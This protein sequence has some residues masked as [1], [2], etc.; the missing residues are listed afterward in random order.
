VI[1]ADDDPQ[2]VGQRAFGDLI[3]ERHAPR[4]G[5]DVLTRRGTPRGDRVRIGCQRRDLR[6]IR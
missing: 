6:P 3:I 1:L 4:L 2:A 5:D